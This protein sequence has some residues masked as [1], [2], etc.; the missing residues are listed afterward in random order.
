[1]KR[2]FKWIDYFFL[3]LISLIVIVVVAVLFLLNSTKTI[4]WAA[5]R[6]APQY[7]FGYKKISG[8][9]LS[10]LEIEELTFEEDM[11]LD[12]F[13]I[14]W[15]PA[16]LLH[17]KVSVT[18]L[19]A[20]Q[21]NVETIQKVIKAFSSDTPKKE[22]NGTFELPV[23]IGLNDLHLSVKPFAE[24]GVG[25]EKV[26]LDGKKLLLD[27][28]HLDV[29]SLE[30]IVDT[31]TT[32]ISLTASVTDGIVRVKDFSVL[33]I[34]LLALKSVVESVQERQIHK[35]VQEHTEVVI[36]RHNEGDS[37]YIPHKILIDSVTATIKPVIHDGIR[38]DQIELQSHAIEVRPHKIAEG[39]SNA[40]QIKSLSLYVDTNLTK[41]RLETK[42]KGDSVIV[43]SLSLREID[44]LALTKLL[45]LTETNTTDRA[46]EEHATPENAED[47]NE[48]HVASPL[49]SPLIPKYLIIKRLDTS[50]LSATYDP[51]LVESAE[52][53]ATNIKFN[54]H[55]LIAES[56]EIDIS[57]ASSF[58]NLIQHGIIKN[59]QIESRGYVTPL[60]TL[61]ETYKIPLREDALG[62]I[63]LNIDASRE[64]AVVDILINGKE[65]LQTEEGKFNVTI[66][67][68]ANQITYLIPEKKLIVSSEGD[69]TT[70]YTK[71]LRL[72]NLLT[73][74]NSLLAYKGEIRPGTIEGIDS[75][76]TKPLNDLKIAYHGDEKSIEALIDSKGV[77][78]KFV[79][80]DFKKADFNL[81]TKAPLVL[82][83]MISLPEKLQEAR[84]AFDIQVPLDFAK[85]TPLKA[86]AKITSNMAN[87]NAD[88]VYD[89]EIKVLTTTQFPKES[90][91]RGF[92]EELN[93][94]AF[95]PLVAN[96]SMSED[97][98]KVNVKSNGLTSD[99]NYGLSD[100]NITGDLV[101]GG[102]T[103]LFGGNIEEEVSLENSVGSLQSLIKKMNTIYTFEAPPI[104]GDLKVSLRLKKM[105]DVELLLTSNALTYKAD[106]TTEHKLNDTMI[107]LG[108]SDS[109]LKL[110]RYHSTFQ[111]QKIFATK[112]SV[113]SLKDG[114]V[115][116]S[117]LWVN[118]AL[119]VTGNYN[120]EDKKG[121]IL[122]YADPF[123]LSHKMIDLS[124]K[125]DI[126]TKLDGVK[127]KIDGVVTIQGGVVH[128]DLDQKSFPSDSDIIIV[129]NMKKREPSPFMDN[130]DAT[131]IVNTA[132][133]LLYK[134]ADANVR[135]NT[136]LMI[137]KAPM[138]PLYVLGTAEVIKG[139]YYIFEAKKFVFKKSLIAFTGNPLKPIL[140]ISVVYNSLNYEITIQVT[141]D[142]TTPNIIFSSLP[143]L[144]QGEILSV[145]LF[146]SEDG[147]GSN[148]GEDMMKMMGG[149][150]AKSVLSNVGIKI[151]HLSLGTDGSMEIGKKIS[152]KVTIIYVN[153]EVAGAKLQY[154]YSRYIKGV[155]ST[156]SESSAAGIVYR[157]DFGEF[158]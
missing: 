48:I 40:I 16:P 32:N 58:A 99:I 88:V 69:V 156:D 3:S 120:I 4:E 41:L 134:T 92:S 67:R 61:F 53:N 102:A 153:E 71:N 125:I 39:K 18:H 136:D 103:F 117:P 19:S 85:I 157:R 121:E 29:G 158:E 38:V 76:Y 124:S 154:D 12:R 151:D 123:N 114:S 73:F 43:D 21:L 144:S 140:D 137:E 84:V 131:I 68:L 89:K 10:G 100:K 49:E 14:G 31:N 133:P 96:L 54:I 11:L 24:S 6:Y 91:L 110:N 44:T 129:Q 25:F 46:K 77:K 56:G 74:E 143:Q 59:N 28:T 57:V 35:E 109:V 20:T 8:G 51:V 27:A 47:V 1:M 64:K 141:G 142:P 86:K 108:F 65:I 95:N 9:L 83:D 78:G 104:D 22:D 132:K 93:L 98:V 62:N 72:N 81:S 94:N 23:S 139:S 113:I 87:L 34:N 37:R 115:E 147:A 60:K 155:I 135:V 97:I 106:R 111:E 30:L 63:T 26:T 5:D 52:V 7:G 101:L 126:K 146:D 36:E 80:P 13:K 33:D 127:T 79:S 90:L 128:Y 50:I 42:L 152:D 122:A 130:L 150:M 107:S 145:I 2:L 75:N 70:P 138:G 45:T 55:K 116:I 148:S 17:Q 66:L 149:A 118:D 15:N 105:K 112:P 82:K 119:K